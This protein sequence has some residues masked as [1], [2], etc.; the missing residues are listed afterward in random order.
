MLPWCPWRDLHPHA[1]YKRQVLSL[2]CLLFHHR[3]MSGAGSRAWTDNLLFT[4]QLLYQLSYPSEMMEERQ[5]FEP[6]IP[7]GITVFGTVSLSQ[8]RTSLRCK[9]VAAVRVE[10]TTQGFS[11]PR[12]TSW[13][14]QP[15][16]TD[17]TAT[18]ALAWGVLIRCRVVKTHFV[19]F[20]NF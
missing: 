12:S 5:G 8:T 3:D 11:G 19:R 13:A 6:W 7:H 2:L 10:L 9:L 17:G 16:G 4:R 14:T 20:N 18:Q 1:H 15:N